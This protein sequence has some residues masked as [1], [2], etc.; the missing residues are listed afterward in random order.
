[1]LVALRAA[2]ISAG[3]NVGAV[4]F[5]PIAATCGYESSNAAQSA[6]RSPWEICC[7]SRALKLIHAL[8]AGGPGKA[9]ETLIYKVYVDG[10]VNLDL[11]GSS[12][13]SVI[14]LIVVMGLTAVQFRYIESRVHYG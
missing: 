6:R 12:A 10:V 4:Q 8:T 14:L 11:G 13:Q 9:T 5:T 1:M 2:R 7:S 3:I